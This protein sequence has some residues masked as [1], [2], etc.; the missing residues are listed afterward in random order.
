MD[1]PS[2]FEKPAPSW[3][4]HGLQA[5]CVA[6]V[7]V[8][9]LPLLLFAEAALVPMAGLLLAVALW[10]LRRGAPMADARTGR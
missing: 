8:V 6:L 7:T 4:R 3:L 2:L 10:S 1:Y 9:A 5:V